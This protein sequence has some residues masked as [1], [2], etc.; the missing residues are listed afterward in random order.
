MIFL[1]K[2]LPL[3]T[4]HS[5]L[6][7]GMKDQ[8]KYKASQKT[9]IQV[10]ISTLQ[11]A[12]QARISVTV[13]KILCSSPLVHHPTAGEWG[14]VPNPRCTKPFAAS[15]KAT[16]HV[17]HIPELKSR[18]CCGDENLRT[19]VPNLEAKHKAEMRLKTG[20]FPETHSHP[21]KQLRP[22]LSRLFAKL[23]LA[24][25]VRPG[26]AKAEEA[27]TQQAGCVRG[28]RHN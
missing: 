28:L 1:S 11:V 17:L 19:N 6:S 2:G 4:Y 24:H 26:S 10:E 14:H 27:V 9:K 15:R 8:A 20:M 13:A 12:R 18:M 23:R 7:T 22:K 25:D 3:T 5:P 21:G 16:P